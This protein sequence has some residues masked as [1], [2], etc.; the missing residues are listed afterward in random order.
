[1]FDARTSRWRWSPHGAPNVSR[2]WRRCAIGVE[3]RLADDRTATHPSV[4]IAQWLRR[5]ALSREGWVVV[6]TLEILEASRQLGCPCN[7]SGPD[8]WCSCG[9]S[10]QNPA[11]TMRALELTI[12]ETS[13]HIECVSSCMFCIPFGIWYDCAWKGLHQV[14]PLEQRTVDPLEA[15]TERKGKL[16]HEVDA[17]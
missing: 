3:D 13:R 17:C 12:G 16:G 1:M 5:L 11:S 7:H 4:A 6:E 9:C 15:S 8:V 2:F 14:L 10:C